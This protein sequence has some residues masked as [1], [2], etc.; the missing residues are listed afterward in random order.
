MTEKAC[1]RCNSPLVLVAITSQRYQD[2]KYC[3]GGRPLDAV[4]LDELIER[5]ADNIEAS[6]RSNESTSYFEAL[7]ALAIRHFADCNVKW[8]IMEAGLGGVTDATNVFGSGQVHSSP[9]EHGWD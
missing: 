9:P 1:G 3:A 7:T 5:Y 8:S 4:E 6:I 2:I